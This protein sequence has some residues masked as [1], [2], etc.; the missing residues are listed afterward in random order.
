M[1]IDFDSSKIILIGGAPRSGTTLVQRIVASH[2]LVFGGP[3]FDLVP[4]VMKLRNIFHASVDAGRISAYLN[5]T[6]VD[7][8]FREFLV[9]AFNMA[10]QANP[11]RKYLS[12]KTPANAEVFAEIAEVL[13]RAQLIFVIRDPRAI[14]ASM[15]EVGNRFRTEGLHPAEFTRNV[16][17]ATRY[18]NRLWT[19]VAK[20]IGKDGVHV[21]C[22]EDI[23]LRPNVF[24]PDLAKNLG[25][26]FEAG[27]VQ[28]EKQQTITAE[29]KSAEHLWYSKE[30]L[31]SAIDNHSLEKWKGQLT[32]YEL[33]VI[34]KS[35]RRIPGL[36]DR[37]QLSQP[38]NPIFYAMNFVGHIF[39]NAIE[40]I[41][42]IGRKI[43][44]HV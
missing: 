44:A 1:S 25:L 26:E 13:P 31:Q 8:I 33:Y 19:A 4:S 6:D 34:D 30:R 39:L 42:R 37:Y 40:I 22:Y 9:S 29:F 15:L 28:I 10:M 21:V 16:Q 12:E 38:A 41:G 36:T 11:N 2:S 35:L 43:Y 23:V 5:H 27:M 24:I 18:I 17:R 20:V 14:V 7:Y 3:E 32:A